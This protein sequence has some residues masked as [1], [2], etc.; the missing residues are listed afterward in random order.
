[1]EELIAELCRRIPDL[2]DECL[3]N[4]ERIVR[5]LVSKA[6]GYDKTATQV[7]QQQQIAMQ[8]YWEIEHGRLDEAVNILNRAR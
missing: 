1:M 8:I 4:R 6:S 3:E 7:L 5:S 2:A